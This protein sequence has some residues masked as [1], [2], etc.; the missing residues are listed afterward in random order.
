MKSAPY[1]IVIPTVG[2][3]S[4]V[5]TLCAL[6]VGAGPAPERVLLVDDR[7]GHPPPLPLPADL[8][9]LTGRVE[10]H[11]RGGGGPAAARNVG[12]R[13]AT[14]PW[15]VFLDDDVVPTADW[16]TDL[17]RDLAACA[18]GSQGRI[19]V[20][21]PK[22]RRATDWE[23]NVAG[24][25]HA[26]WATADMAYRRSALAEVGGFDV[27]FPRAYR[28]DAD[29]GL[30]MTS[31]G[32]AITVGRRTVLHPVRPAPWHVS[33]GKQAGNV[34]DAL[35]DRLH[36][37]GWRRR[38]G[39]PR[40]D[41]RR[42]LATTA[43]A[44]AAVAARVGRRRRLARLL[45]LAWAGLVGELAVRRVRPGPRTPSEV[46]A[47]VVTSAALGPAATVAYLGGLVRARRLVGEGGG[48]DQ[49]AVGSQRSDPV[50][51]VLFDRDGTLIVDVP[52]NGDPDRVAPM[53]AARAALDRLRGAGLPVAIVSNQSGVARGMLELAEVDAVNDRVVEL[54]GPFSA[55]VVCPHGPDDGCPGRKPGPGMVQ[56]AAAELGV[57]PS[58]CVVVGDIGAD[59]EAA[60]AAGARAILVP[61]DVTRPQEI[62]AAPVV[63]DDIAVAVDLVLAGT[64]SR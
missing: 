57:P 24:L 41:R 7:A 31:A 63:V 14:A 45:A 28:E 44:G 8:G 17:M 48:P 52:Y 5:E 1:D 35:M 3:A 58:R 12:W 30:R 42:H 22:H 56:R 36:G 9:I 54:L 21:L 11:R 43:V 13:A 25:A 16:A 60:Q 51:A 33:I 23:R 6:R 15:I 62:E 39:A 34:D 50:E 61:T 20:P 32:H 38:A 49:V 40:G 29:L 53:P 59:V 10:V 27:R 2:R 37:S 4:L 64:V 26:S 19:V 47:M 18:A 46:A 55:V